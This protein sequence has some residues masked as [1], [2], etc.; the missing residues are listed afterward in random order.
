MPVWDHLDELRERVLVSGLACAVAILTCFAF[1]KDLVVFL[2][3]PVVTQVRAQTTSYMLSIVNRGVHHMHI[4]QLAI[5]PVPFGDVQDSLH[6]GG[7]RR[8]Q[9]RACR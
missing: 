5:I 4:P 2:E 6:K 8:L 1:S 7:A 9:Q 3:A